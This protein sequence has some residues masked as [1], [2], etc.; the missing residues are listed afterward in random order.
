MIWTPEEKP[1]PD[2]RRVVRQEMPPAPDW[3]LIEQAYG[4]AGVQRAFGEYHQQLMTFGIV[5]PCPKHGQGEIRFSC[6]HVV[7][8]QCP[9][10][11]HVGIVCTVDG[12][13]VCKTC[14]KLIERHKFKFEREI[15]TNCRLCILELAAKLKEINPELLIDNTQGRQ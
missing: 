6:R 13:Y 3:H 5:F 2:E 4:P 9:P 15:G 1:K 14:W 8:D 11:D 7:H 12:Y 10:E